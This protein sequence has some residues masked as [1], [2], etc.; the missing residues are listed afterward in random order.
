MLGEIKQLV[1]EGDSFALETSLKNFNERY[2]PIVDDWQL[3]NNIGIEPV[4]IDW[5]A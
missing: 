3:Y 4:L 5:K 1:K 2:K